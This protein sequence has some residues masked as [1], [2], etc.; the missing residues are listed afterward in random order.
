MTKPRKNRCETVVLN[1]IEAVIP[2]FK[3]KHSCTRTCHKAVVVLGCSIDE[4][5]TAINGTVTKT[6][7]LPTSQYKICRNLKYH[8][9]D[10]MVRDP[11]PAGV[12][13]TAGNNSTNN[14]NNNVAAANNNTNTNAASN[15][16][17]GTAI[18]GGVDTTVAAA[19][20]RPNPPGGVGGPGV[21][22]GILI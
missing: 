5:C 14:T 11:P 21:V 13:V 2:G 16:D 12:G 15:P 8:D 3:H 7:L 17:P 22:G 9:I 19:A 20:S 18:G 6:T 10:N 1:A 4:Y